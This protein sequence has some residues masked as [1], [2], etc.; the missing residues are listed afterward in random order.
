[1]PCTP[2]TSSGGSDPCLRPRSLVATKGGPAYGRSNKAHPEG[3]AYAAGRE[4]AGAARGPRVS[5]D[6]TGEAAE[7]QRHHGSTQTPMCQGAAWT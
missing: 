7:R 1:M 2:A 4:R 5:E 6:D 3:G